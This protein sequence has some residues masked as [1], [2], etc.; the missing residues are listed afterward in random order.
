[1]AKYVVLIEAHPY[2]A[3]SPA[4]FDKLR[5]GDLEIIDMR[6]KGVEDPEFMEALKGAD[7]LLAGNDINVT[8]D[9]L[10]ELPKLKMIGKFGVGLD[11]IDLDACA[12]KGVIVCNSPGCNTQAVADQA[13]G[14]L[15]ALYR[16]IP[17]GDSELRRGNYSHADMIGREAWK[18][19]MGIVGL[20]SIGRA[21]AERAKGFRMD[22]IGFDPYWPE[23]FAK[24]NDIKRCDTVEELLPQVDVLTLHCNLTDENKHMINKESLATMKP[25]AVIINTARGG[26]INENDLFDALQSGVVAGAGIDAWTNEP[27]AGSPLLSL[28]N[29]VV[30][31]HSAAFTVESLQNMDMMVTEQI[32]AFTKDEQPQPTVNKVEIKK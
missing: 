27:P 28:G 24:E 1:M 14:L 19:T 4:A 20:G 9:L 32:L 2:C 6:G 12:E 31:P 5:T 18:K 25:N 30:M 21:V 15:L 26:L 8:K 29:V 17:K 22:I 23:E 13:M 10:A 7:I 11:A 3:S 16:S